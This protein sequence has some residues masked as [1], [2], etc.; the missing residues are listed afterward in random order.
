MPTAQGQMHL[1]ETR[2]LLENGHVHAQVSN[3]SSLARVYC[4]ALDSPLCGLV[5]KMLQVCI[6]RVF[7]PCERRFS[8]LKNR[9]FLSIVLGDL[10]A[11]PFMVQVLHLSNLTTGGKCVTRRTWVRVPVTPLDQE[12][13]LEEVNLV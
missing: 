4:R 1:V 7:H 13:V 3:T 5:V 9:T 10:A 6:P 8:L 2:Q 11:S 12:S